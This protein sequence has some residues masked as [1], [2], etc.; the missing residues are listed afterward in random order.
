MGNENSRSNN[1]YSSNNYPSN[2]SS[3]N[4]SSNN[5]SS[6]NYSS[7]N[8]NSAIQQYKQQNNSKEQNI[9]KLMRQ[10]SLGREEAVEVL[11]SFNNDL[12]EAVAF[13][14]WHEQ[15]KKEK[16][17]K[18]QEEERQRQAQLRLRQQQQQQEEERRRQMQLQVARRQQDDE[19]E[20]EAKEEQLEQFINLLASV[21]LIEKAGFDLASQENCDNIIAK[22][23]KVKCE[24]STMLRD[25]ICIGISHLLKL[26]AVLMRLK[27]FADY[28]FVHIVLTDG[29]D[30][31]SKTTVQELKQLFK[32]L[33][34]EIGDACKTYFIGVRL[35]S[36]GTKDL[37]EIASLAGNAA[38]FL[39]C[40]DVGISDI[41]N[42]IQLQLVRR[43][44]VAVIGNSQMAIV[45]T[46]QNYG[47]ELAVNHYLV[48]FTLDISGSMAGQRWK[49]VIESVSKFLQS[50]PSR[51]I[52]GI[53]LFNDE[54]KII[55]GSSE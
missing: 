4:Y 37:K 20:D 18:Q 50:M 21:V 45:A 54:I 13:C 27:A 6:N 2:Y 31:G 49:Q 28:K 40:D 1:N 22:L 11:T 9:Q 36:Q 34:E 38:E 24:K 29:E 42:H 25:G 12:S 51:D 44:E 5:Y 46:R 35:D 10:F 3:N 16:L 55:T 14:E 23:K 53:L 47:L 39:K 26:K 15:D 32:M 48:L 8:T 33:N 30:T 43:Q 41:F 52:F 7:N 19:P 17:R